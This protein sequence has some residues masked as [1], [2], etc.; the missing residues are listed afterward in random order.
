MRDGRSGA[1]QERAELGDGDSEATHVV[2]EGDTVLCLGEPAAFEVERRD[3]V[4]DLG[5]RAEVVGHG[6]A[7][8]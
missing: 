7:D 2:L 3:R 6:L 4:A 1:E 8:D 5:E